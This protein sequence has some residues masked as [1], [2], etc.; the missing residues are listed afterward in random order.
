MGEVYRARD[1]RL[2]RDVAIKVLP[3]PRVHDPERLRRF[4]Q[5]ARAAG[6]LSHPNVLAVLDVGTHD[7]AP[8]VVYELLEG[9][10]LRERI[11]EGNLTAVKAISHAVQI[12]HGLAAAH[13]KGIVHRDLKPENLFVTRSGH[14]KILDFGLVKLQ[15]PLLSEASSSPPTTATQQ[16]T[17][18]AILGTVAYM[19]P[20]QAQGLPA[21]ERSDIFSFGAVLYEMLTGKPAFR[22]GSA[23]QTLVAILKEDP[24][25]SGSDQ[26]P[27]GVAAIVS[28]CLEKRPPDR[29]H[30]AHDLA[31]ALEATAGSTGQVAVARPRPRPWV[32]IAIG[33]CLLATLG[34]LWWRLL[35]PEPGPPATPSTAQIEAVTRAAPV[36][37]RAIA[38]LPL[39]DLSPDRGQ[40]SF[41][42]AMTD[43]VITELG[44]TRGLRVISRTSMMQY[45]RTVKPMAQIASELKAARVVEGSVL[46][47]GKRVRIDVG[48]IDAHTDSHLKS[49]SYDRDL[50]DILGLQREVATTIAAEIG[51]L[52][53]ESAYAA[54][55]KSTPTDVPLPSAAPTYLPTA[56][57]R[58]ATAPPAA[59]AG[60]RRPPRALPPAAAAAPSAPGSVSRRVEPEAYALYAQGLSFLNRGREGSDRKAAEASLQ[61]SAVFF[62]QAVRKD[63][64]YAE[65]HLGLALAYFELVSRGRRNFYPRAKEAAVRAIALD[66]SLAD[67]HAALAFALYRSEWDW[68]GAE[69]HYRRALE[70]NP[71]SEDARRGY[72][73]F[74]SAVG[75]HDPAIAQLKE[76]L[77]LEPLS[78]RLKA[79]LAGAYSRAGQFE[80]AF[81][82]YRGLLA[83]PSA[84][85]EDRIDLGKAYVWARRADLGVGEIQRA[86]SESGG[87]P[88]AKAA[89]AWALA[90]SGR[91]TEA[92]SLLVDLEKDPSSDPVELGSVQV[93]LGDRDAAMASLER[94]Y[95]ARRESL[96]DLKGPDFQDLQSDPRFLGFLRRV[97]FP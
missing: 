13:A 36:P 29:F 44:R 31:L 43:A 94:A 88:R 46:R 51:N 49:W 75:R 48:L 17:P 39:Q 61:T 72:G 11:R 47:L 28:R 76:A 7:E 27:P 1:S 63:P 59:L 55:P 80:P 66:E 9:A 86:A 90:R 45:K 42:D 57:P 69:R 41:A 85:L 70:L 60:I 38:V 77:D 33:A 65:G 68:A 56:A 23:A 91:E 96:A 81:E 14:V 37:F 34:L 78:D 35:R 32:W 8:F 87:P 16:T 18:G 93:A 24:P 97:G 19:S 21:D 84:D 71:S 67:A 4:E 50:R 2:G 20:E 89:L 22:K 52:G 58:P 83:Q 25:R 40:G 26:L 62:A 10:T 82:I 79:N 64:S 30:S 74:L 3:D 15:A 5:E 54:A 95:R 6:A 73:L 53:D 12:A 92:R